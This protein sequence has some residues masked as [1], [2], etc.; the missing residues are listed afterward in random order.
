M[1]SML[2]PP[3]TRAAFLLLAALVLPAADKP[4]LQWIVRNA[5]TNV[6]HTFDGTA[7]IDVG[8][9]LNPSAARRAAAMR[10]WTG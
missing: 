5:N 8:R 2:T 3:A 4:R 9:V 10:P 1:L 7:T 6:T